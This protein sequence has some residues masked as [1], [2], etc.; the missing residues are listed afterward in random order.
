MTEG[1]SANKR[2]NRN[3]FL[4]FLKTHDYTAVNTRFQKPP[5][6]PVT[7]KEKVPQHNPARE[8]CEGENMGPFD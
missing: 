2:D 4:D 7:Y 1:I 8:E 5:H 6:E 3:R